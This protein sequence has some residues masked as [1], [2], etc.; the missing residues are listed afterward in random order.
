MADGWV[1]IHRKVF[2]NEL[3]FS[4]KFTR[5]Q[6]FFDLV[7]LA[8]YKPQSYIQRGIEKKLAIGQLCITVRNLSQRWQWSVTK[9]LHFLCELE[10][11][12][13]AKVDR[14]KT[15]NIITISNYEKY[16]SDTETG[17]QTGT[18]KNQETGTPE[19]PLNPSK[20]SKKEGGI[21][22]QTGTNTI[23]TPKKPINTSDTEGNL[24]DY[25]TQI[26]TPN[27]EDIGTQ[28]PIYIEEK[29]NIPPTPKGYESFDFSFVEEIW[30]APF[31]SWL[32]YKRE[33][34]EKYKSQ[35]SLETCY[36]R[37]KKLSQN[38]IE[39]AEQIVEQSKA[40]NYAGLFELRKRFQSRPSTG[41]A[42]IAMRANEVKTNK[43]FLKP[44]ET[45]S[46][47]RPAK[48]VLAEIMNSKNQ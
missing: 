6:A 27:K 22:T 1:K 40:N 24:F 8:A 48:E 19:K 23:G 34:K 3:Y 5:F 42:A 37:L 10:S 47:G 21:G 30:I 35:D 39:A 28:P 44:G 31:Y 29:K 11:L 41:V 15:S 2:E 4:E 33:R 13:M 18:L 20:S 25:G 36:N 38:N 17:T 26:G 16:Q 32:N 14:C 43:D 45:Y 9:V 46:V 12:K 7:L